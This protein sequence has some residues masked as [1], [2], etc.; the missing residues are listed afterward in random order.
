M[1][2]TTRRAG[3]ADAPELHH[4]AALTFGLATPPGTRQTDI[5]AFIGEHLAEASFAAYLADPARI[6]LLAEVD[7]TAVGYAMLI[8]GP[9]SDPEVAAVVRSAA[10]GTATTIEL[11]KFYVAP[12]NHGSG[13]AATLMTATLAAA[14][15]TGAEVC[16][17]GVNQL[18]QRAAKFYAKHGFEI[19]GTKRFLVGAVWHDDHVRARP[20]TNGARPA[21]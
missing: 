13:V 4:L 9:I 8:D 7:G 15:A 2:I 16:W 11:S 20:L 6:V 18:N 21:G 10:P 1:A 19:I 17:L 14:A 12:D 3:P 5:D